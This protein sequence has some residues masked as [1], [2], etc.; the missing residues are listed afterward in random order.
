VIATNT[1]TGPPTPQTGTLRVCKVAGIGIFP[2]TPYDFLIRQL[3]SGAATPATIAAG[4]CSS[5][6][7]IPAGTTVEVTETLPAG[8]EV[9]PLITSDPVSELRTCPEPAPTKACASI[10][11][12]ATTEL[13]FLNRSAG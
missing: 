13:R 2:G 4:F 7:G 6:P 3:T 12:G 10:S 1:K 5:F 11:G 8:S 9:P